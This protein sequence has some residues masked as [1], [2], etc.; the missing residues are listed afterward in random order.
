MIMGF[1]CHR[2]LSLQIVTDRLLCFCGPTIEP[3]RQAPRK[4]SHRELMGDLGA[5]KHHC[6]EILVDQGANGMIRNHP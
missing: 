4:L 2:T 3:S 1:S 6:G 5:P